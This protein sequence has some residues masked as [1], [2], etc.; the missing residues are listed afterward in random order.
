LSIKSLRELFVGGLPASPASRGIPLHR[1]FEELPRFKDFLV[2]D[3]N[4]SGFTV[5]SHYYAVRGFLRWAKREGYNFVSVDALRSYL[6]TYLGR[7]K[8]T[9]ANL[10][11]G[12]RRFFRDYLECPE[13]VSSFRLPYIRRGEGG[14]L[15]ELW[16]TKRD[17]QRVYYAL[18]KSKNP[19]RNQALF[20]LYA[21]TGLRRLEL[22][23]LQPRH[24]DWSLRSI[25]LDLDRGTKK[26]GITFFNQEAEVAL[27][28]MD[29]PA[30]EDERIFK[31][32]G[33]GV[34]WVLKRASRRCGVNPPITPQALR[35]WFSYEMGKLGVPDRY[36]DIF[37]GR[38]PNS[39][40]AQFY[41]PR[42]LREL[43][44]VYDKAGLKVL[45]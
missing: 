29:L 30:S 22:L 16:F 41:T 8:Y 43:K 13:L 19:E 18:G 21:T 3:L 5:E 33:P 25:I 26:T 11:K 10:I 4:L 15:K 34:K 31:I 36:I 1:L 37:Q 9:R 38:V 6:K 35:V 7:S 23:E 32:R 12:F 40:L 24:I 20:L 45:E 17:L 14:R 42:G 39:M 44:E 27:K 28:R 2:V